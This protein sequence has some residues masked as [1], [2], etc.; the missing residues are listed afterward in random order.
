MTHAHTSIAE[1]LNAAQLVIINTLDDAEI[2]ALVAELGYNA[3]KV[4]GGRRL[5]EA[6]II[7]VNAR[8]L[9]PVPVY[10]AGCCV[11]TP[12]RVTRNS[13]QPEIHLHRAPAC[14]FQSRMTNEHCF[15]G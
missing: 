1:Q 3:E 15:T 5:Y 10:R 11:F 6:A 4:S 13:A 7:A 8:P 9:C 12:T 14:L 2:K